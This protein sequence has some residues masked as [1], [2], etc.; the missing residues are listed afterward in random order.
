MEIERK[1][2]IQ[3]LPDLSCYPHKTIVQAY[4]STDPVIRIRRLATDYYLC[5]KSKGSLMRE[6]FELPL[7]QV[8]FEHLWS[9]IEGHPISKT[10]YYIPLDDGLTAEL[11]CYE[12]PLHGL[13]T[14]EVEF[15]CEHA[16]HAFI[17]PTWFGKDI[18]LDNRYKNNC[19]A[20]HGLPKP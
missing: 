12:A 1:F 9:K 16:A 7:T 2:L 20:L 13:T 5:V 8:Q 18:T 11:D 19:L 17:P 3:T 14:V 15:H 6:E 10:R 4:V